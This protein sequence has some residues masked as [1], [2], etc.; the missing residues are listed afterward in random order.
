MRI[1]R[2][3]WEEFVPP[4]ER[5]VYCGLLKVKELNPR[6]N[7]TM[8]YTSMPKYFVKYHTEVEG[9]LKEGKRATEFHCNSNRTKELT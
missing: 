1:M 7:N 8:A 9:V 4:T 5:C 3:S 6:W 2:H